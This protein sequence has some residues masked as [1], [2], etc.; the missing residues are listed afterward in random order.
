MHDPAEALAAVREN[1]AAAAARSGRKAEDIELIA[2]SKTHGPDAVRAVA[3]AGQAVFGESRVQEARAKLTLLPG[4][5]RWQF[6]G[7]LQKNKIRQA[8]PLFELFHSMDS[9]DLARQVHRIAD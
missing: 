4:R 8:L 6:I 1:I 2:I 7:H 5:L 9:L 3:E